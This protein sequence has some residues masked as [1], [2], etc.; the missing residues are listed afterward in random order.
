MLRIFLYSQFLQQFLSLSLSL[1][2][3]VWKEYTIILYTHLLEISRL[4]AGDPRSVTDD[5][6]KDLRATNPK[7]RH[8]P[9]SLFVFFLLLSRFVSRRC[10]FGWPQWVGSTRPGC[11][12]SA[13]WSL[14]G[15]HPQKSPRSF[16]ISR[17]FLSICVSW[18]H[19]RFSRLFCFFL[20][21]F[22]FHMIYIWSFLFV[23][24]NASLF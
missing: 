7:S 19:D 18:F 8:S 5:E 11:S 17:F 12:S 6:L 3:S 9:K 2:L 4:L 13:R 10:G 15:S 22:F 16:R 1:S 20:L 14:S 23:Q 24:C 21:I